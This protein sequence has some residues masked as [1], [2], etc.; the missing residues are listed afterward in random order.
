MKKKTLK[1]WAVWLKDKQDFSGCIPMVFDEKNKIKMIIRNSGLISTFELKKFA[2][3]YAEEL[4]KR[5]NYKII[6][7]EIIYKI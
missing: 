1:A 5:N 3:M 2:K 6:P 4:H 7:I